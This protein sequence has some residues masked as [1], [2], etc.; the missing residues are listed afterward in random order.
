[1]TNRHPLTFPDGLDIDV[2]PARALCHAWR[3]ASE[4][5]QREHT[6]PYFWEAGLR[7]HNVEDPERRFERYR[8]TVDYPEDYEL[9]RRIFSALYD[10]RPDFGTADVIAYLDR[11]PEVAALNARYLPGAVVTEVA[12]AR[13]G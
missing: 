2:I 10:A 7:V 4:P 12:H 9:V 3:H 13:A 5:H 11:H 8:W 1:V 6:I